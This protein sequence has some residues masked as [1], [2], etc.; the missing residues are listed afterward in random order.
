MK[1]TVTHQCYNEHYGNYLN[2]PEVR[3]AIHVSE[4]IQNRKWEECNSQ[5]LH[6]DYEQIYLSMANVFKDIVERHN[7]TNII[8]YNGDADI[9]CDFM[10]TQKFLLDKMKLELSEPSSAWTTNGKTA[11]LKYVFANGIKYYTIIGAGH[12][13]P[14][15][16]PLQAIQIFNEL[17][18]H[19]A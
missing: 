3:K 7:F 6:H 1:H 11:G 9:V 5:I 17:I 8:L 10:H 15:H 13:V 18:H 16:K 12:Y 14:A 4:S 19:S 2:L